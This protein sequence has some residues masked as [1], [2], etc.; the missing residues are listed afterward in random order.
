MLEIQY[1]FTCGCSETFHKARLP[2]PFNSLLPCFP[3]VGLIT[4]VGKYLFS[5]SLLPLPS[6]STSSPCEGI[7]CLTSLGECQPPPPTCCFFPKAFFFC[8]SSLCLQEVCRDHLKGNSLLSF[9]ALLI[10]LFG[11]RFKNS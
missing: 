8:H 3:S 9:K 10:F 11:Y 5:Y 4:L 2:K 7:L 6:R 1:C